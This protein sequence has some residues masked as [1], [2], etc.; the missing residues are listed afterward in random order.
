MR[1]I[2]DQIL[3]GDPVELEFYRKSHRLF[4]LE[5]VPGVVAAALLAYL[6]AAVFPPLEGVC[7]VAFLMLL[8]LMFRD[9]WKSIGCRHVVLDV[10]SR[11]LIIDQHFPHDPRRL[12]ETIPFAD[13][14]L[15]EH[16][17]AEGESQSAAFVVRLQVGKN[18]SRP[19]L[20]GYLI[21]ETVVEYR[22]REESP[23]DAQ[24][25]THLASLQIAQ[26]VA[27]FTGIEFMDIQ[28][29]DTP[30]LPERG[31]QP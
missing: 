22:D 18:I 6:P 11:T 12:S 25:R 1:D 9:L 3:A 19:D 29:P 17:R 10:Q 15:L 2:V 14:L 7:L 26:R 31:L 4:A 30:G 21:R 28:G 27:G 5:I 13:L 20:S 16:W 23:A 24:R 8:P